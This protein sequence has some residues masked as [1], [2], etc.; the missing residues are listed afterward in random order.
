[1][2]ALFAAVAVFLCTGMIAAGESP[3]EPNP[4][5]NGTGVDPKFQQRHE[6]FVETAKKGGVGLLLM[7]DSITAGWGSQ[8]AIYEKAFGPYKPANFGIGGDRTQHVLWRLHNGELDGITPKVMMLMIGTNNTGG[9]Q[10]EPVAEGVTAIVNFVKKKSPGTKILLLAV[11]PRGAKKEGNAARVKIDKINEVIAKLDD[12]GKTVKYLDIGAKFLEPDGSISK[13]IMPD[14]L[15]LSAKGYQ[16]W[17]D[18]V[19]P[20]LAEMMK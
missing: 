19:A 15:H 11:F 4:K 14:A 6:A 7:G 3:S 8:K 13:E 5:R 9:D 10:P 12:G 2:R 20:T 16:I 1:M 17:A 18:A